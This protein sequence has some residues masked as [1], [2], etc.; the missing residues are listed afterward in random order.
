V[1][2]TT[3]NTSVSRAGL[4]PV[5]GTFAF[6]GA[7]AQTVTVAANQKIVAAI[8]AAGLPTTSF[9]IDY[10]ICY[11]VP[12]AIVT[13]LGPSIPSPS[14]AEVDLTANNAQSLT[15][16]YAGTL[17]AGTYMVG[18]CASQPT[19]ATTTAVFEAQVGGWVLVTN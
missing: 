5:S 1:S 12:G 16:T 19:G 13:L 18:W 14:T 2:L 4:I 6:L 7:S 9:S 3:Y 8:T 17:P 11:Q 15:A 10:G